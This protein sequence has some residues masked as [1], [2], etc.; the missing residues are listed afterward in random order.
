MAKYELLPPVK[1]YVLFQLY[2]DAL[3][4]KYGL[5]RPMETVVNME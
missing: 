4:A 1:R 2:L 3:W 5:R